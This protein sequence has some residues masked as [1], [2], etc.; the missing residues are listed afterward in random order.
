ME[1]IYLLIPISLIFL[2]IAVLVFFWAV[3]N[4]QY[5]D[6]KKESTQFLIDEAEDQKRLQQAE[7]KNNTDKEQDKPC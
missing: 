1:A 6:L 3:N 7:E 5:S 4:D 2:I